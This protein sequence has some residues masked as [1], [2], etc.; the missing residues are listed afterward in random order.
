MISGRMT[1]DSGSGFLFHPTERLDN[2]QAGEVCVTKSHLS[3]DCFD[4]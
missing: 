3:V 1:I 2:R 4:W